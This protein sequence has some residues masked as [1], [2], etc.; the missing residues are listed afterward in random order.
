M[1]Q[2]HLEIA[3]AISDQLPCTHVWRLNDHTRIKATGIGHE[4]ARISNSE[5]IVQ[6]WATACPLRKDYDI[7]DPNF[8]PQE[9]I[10]WVIK[11]SKIDKYYKPRYDTEMISRYLSNL[12]Q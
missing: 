8:N 4:L 3:C 2:F 11:L 5:T 10:E 6:R 12:T 1:K 9:L 7:T